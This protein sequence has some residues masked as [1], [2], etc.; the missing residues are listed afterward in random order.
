MIELAKIELNELEAKK[1]KMRV[2]L[3]YF[4]SQK[5]RQIPKMQL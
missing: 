4:C 3:N 1:S 2:N 5:M